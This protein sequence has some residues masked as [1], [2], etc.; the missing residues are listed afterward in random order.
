MGV[1]NGMLGFVG[2]EG[3][4][5]I[6]CGLT[7]TSLLGSALALLALL[8]RLAFG[9]GFSRGSGILAARGAIGNARKGRTG[10]RRLYGGAWVAADRVCG[11]RSAR[12]RW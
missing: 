3:G 7:K 2:V 5:V 12:Q 11:L 6:G 9:L 1:D 10:E 4:G 8:P